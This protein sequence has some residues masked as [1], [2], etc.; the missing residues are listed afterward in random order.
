MGHILLKKYTHSIQKCA[1]LLEKVYFNSYY[2]KHLNNYTQN[3]THSNMNT[4]TQNT[5]TNAY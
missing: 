1:K 3:H 4:Q 2:Y 5:H